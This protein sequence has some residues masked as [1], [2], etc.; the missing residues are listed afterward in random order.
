MNGVCLSE[1]RMVED[2]HSTNT[3][4]ASGSE[5]GAP[6]A[7]YSKLHYSLFLE[8]LSCNSLFRHIPK[9]NWRGEGKHL[10]MDLS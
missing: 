5:N 7:G 6:R 8:H 4:T 3:K 2:V 1:Q 10:N 9:S